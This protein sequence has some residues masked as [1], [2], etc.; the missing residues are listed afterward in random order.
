[1]CK[2]VTVCPGHIWTTLYRGGW[3]GPKV[4]RDGCGKSS[5]IGNFCCS[6]F[7]LY[8]YL[9]ALIAL[10]V[11]FFPY[12]TTHTTQTSMPCRDSNPQSQQ[13]IGR[14]PL[15]L[16]AR[17]L[18][19][20]SRTV[21]PEAAWTWYAKVEKKKFKWLR[22]FNIVLKSKAGSISEMLIKCLPSAA[23]RDLYSWFTLQPDVSFISYAKCV[24][25]VSHSM[26]WQLRGVQLISVE[27]S[28]VLCLCSHS[29]DSVCESS[30][31]EHT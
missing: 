2:Q 17:L 8:S 3:V 12:C 19:F 5:P 6:L 22:S 23:T 13:T 9:F 31:F 27:L 7:I 15:P 29:V 10:A 11:A 21:Q 30:L 26:M 20:D 4:G 28:C 16:T 14:R 1:M 18:G 24:T 25:S